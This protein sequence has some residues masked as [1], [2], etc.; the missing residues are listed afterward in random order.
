MKGCAV[1]FNESLAQSSLSA[2]GKNSS[3]FRSRR[4]VCQRLPIILVREGQKFPLI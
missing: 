3:L 2:W 4:A 1:Q